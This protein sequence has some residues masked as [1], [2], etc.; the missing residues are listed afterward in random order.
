MD[1]TLTLVLGLAAGIAIAAAAGLRA[2][3]PLLAIGLAGRF[4]L[5]HLQ[6]GADWLT[7]TPALVCFGTA[8]VVEI[9]GD[10]IPVVDHALDA[11]GTFLRP[12]AAALAAYG[13]LV[14]WPAPWAQIV[15]LALGAGAFAVHAAKA[16]ARIGSTAVTMG[17]AN[18]V[19]S[20]VEDGVSILI[21]VVA[22]VAPLVVLALL[23]LLAWA[24]VRLFRGRP[25]T[26]APQP[27]SGNR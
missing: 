18:P 19:L 12:I 5:I 16:K 21:V 26:P 22:L 3:L 14:H 4:G 9:V 24:F 11:I 13:V 17:A 23:L 20:V 10:K 25:Q 15:A 27:S 8:T 2:F 6:P 7:G 1:Q